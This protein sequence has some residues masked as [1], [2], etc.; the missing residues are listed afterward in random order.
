MDNQLVCIFCKA[1]FH[2]ADDLL[3]HIRI[4]TGDYPEIDLVSNDSEETTSVVSEATVSTVSE[5]TLSNFN[6]EEKEW[7]GSKSGWSKKDEHLGDKT[8]GGQ[9]YVEDEIMKEKS[10]LDYNCNVLSSNVNPESNYIVEN[11]DVNPVENDFQ[12]DPDKTDNVNRGSSQE[13]DEFGSNKDDRCTSGPTQQELDYLYYL[14]S[15]SNQQP[16]TLQRVKRQLLQQ[17]EDVQ[18]PTLGIGIDSA[19]TMPKIVSVQGTYVHSKAE[20]G[21]QSTRPGNV[22]NSNDVPGSK[23]LSPLYTGSGSTHVE[24]HYLSMQP[25]IKINA[26]PDLMN[27]REDEVPL[28]ISSSRYEDKVQLSSPTESCTSILPTCSLPLPS[29]MTQGSAT[30]PSTSGLFTGS[31]V[32]HPVLSQADISCSLPPFIYQDIGTVSPASRAI[33]RSHRINHPIG[34]PPFPPSPTPNFAASLPRTSPSSALSQLPLHM[35]PLYLS[36]SVSTTPWVPFHMQALYPK[37]NTCSTAPSTMHVPAVDQD[38][39]VPDL[40]SVCI[41]TSVTTTLTSMSPS[42]KRVVPV[43]PTPARNSTTTSVTASTSASS[44]SKSVFPMSPCRGGFLIKSPPPKHLMLSP[45]REWSR[46][47]PKSI[48]PSK[49]SSPKTKTKTVSLSV[50][51]HSDILSRIRYEPHLKESFKSQ[52][53]HQAENRTSLPECTEYKKTKLLSKTE[54]KK[55]VTNSETLCSEHAFGIPPCNKDDLPTVLP[56][57][58]SAESTKSTKDVSTTKEYTASGPLCNRNGLP[59]RVLP[60]VPNKSQE[61]T[62]LRKSESVPVLPAASPFSEEESQSTLH[63]RVLPT[64]PQ[65]SP[66]QVKAELSSIAAGL[67]SNNGDGLQPPTRRFHGEHSTFTASSPSSSGV[68]LHKEASPTMHKRVLPTLPSLSNKRSAELAPST[69]PPSTDEGLLDKSSVSMVDVSRSKGIPAAP[70]S[71]EDVSTELCTKPPCKP[72]KVSTDIST[73]TPKIPSGLFTED[74]SVSTGPCTKPPRK[75]GTVSSGMSVARPKRPPTLSIGGS[76]STGLCTKPPCKFGKASTGTSTTR[77]KGPSI[78]P[79]TKPPPCGPGKRLKGLSS[80]KSSP[81]DSLI[82][83]GSSDLL[84][85]TISSTVSAML[86]PTEE[87]T[88]S[89]NV[90]TKDN[91][92][93]SAEGNTSKLG[94]VSGPSSTETDN[95]HTASSSTQ[96]VPSASSPIKS[97]TSG[98]VTRLPLLKSES[99]DSDDVVVIPPS[100]LPWNTIPTSVHQSV[101]SKNKAVGRQTMKGAACNT[102]HEV[103]QRPLKRKKKSKEARFRPYEIRRPEVRIAC[104]ASKDLPSELLNKTKEIGKKVFKK[105]DEDDRDQQNQQL[106]QS[107]KMP[108]SD[109]NISS[110]VAKLIDQLQSRVQSEEFPMAEKNVC[111]KFTIP[112]DQPQP[113]QSKEFPVAEKSSS[114]KLTKPVVNPIRFQCPTCKRGFHRITEQMKHK[115]KGKQ[116]EKSPNL[117]TAY[118]R[119]KMFKCLHCLTEFATLQEKSQHMC[120]GKSNLKKHDDGNSSSDAKEGKMRLKEAKKKPG[121]PKKDLLLDS[122]YY[123]FKCHKCDKGFLKEPWLRA[124]VVFCQ[125]PMEVEDRSENLHTS[126]EAK[127]VILKPDTVIEQPGKSLQKVAPQSEIKSI[128]CKGCDKMF[129]YKWNLKLHL[130]WSNLC[131]EA[132]DA[133][134]FDKMCA[135]LPKK[136]GHSDESSSSDGKEAEVKGVKRKQGQPETGDGLDSALG[137]FKCQRCDRTFLKEPWMKAHAVFCENPTKKRDKSRKHRQRG[138]I[139]KSEHQVSF[140]PEAPENVQCKGC[141]RF[142]KYRFNLKLHLKWKSTCRLKFNERELQKV[143]GRTHWDNASA[144]I[145]SQD[146]NS[147]TSHSAKVSKDMNSNSMNS[148]DM[149]VQINLSKKNREQK[150][151]SRKPT[152]IQ[153]RKEETDMSSMATSEDDTENEH[154]VPHQEGSTCPFCKDSKRTFQ[155]VQFLSMHTMYAHNK[156]VHAKQSRWYFGD[157]KSVDAASPHDVTG[158]SEE[159]EGSS[160]KQIWKCS[161]CPDVNYVFISKESYI[162]HSVAKHGL[163]AV[164]DSLIS[165]KKEEKGTHPGSGV[166]L[167][168]ARKDEIDKVDQSEV[169]TAKKMSEHPNLHK[170]MQGIDVANQKTKATT[171]GMGKSGTDKRSNSDV[172]SGIKASPPAKVGDFIFVKNSSSV[173]HGMKERPMTESSSSENDVKHGTYKCS[174]CDCGFASPSFAAINRHLMV[175]HNIR[176]PKIVATLTCKDPV[177]LGKFISVQKKSRP[178]FCRNTSGFMICSM[179]NKDVAAENT[180]LHAKKHLLHRLC[181]CT[182]CEYTSFNRGKVRKHLKRVHSDVVEEAM[183]SSKPLEVPEVERSCSPK[184]SETIAT[185]SP[186]TC[187]TIDATSSI[188][189]LETLVEATSRP[190]ICEAI[191]ATS[192][193]KSLG[194]PEA[195]KGL[196]AP[197]MSA[198]ARSPKALEKTE[199]KSSTK[200]LEKTKITTNTKYLQKA[201]ATRSA[202]SLEMAE[203]TNSLRSLEKTE[204]RYDLGPY[205]DIKLHESIGECRSGIKE[206]G[207]KQKYRRKLGGKVSNPNLSDRSSLENKNKKTAIA[208]DKDFFKD[209]NDDLKLYHCKQCDFKSDTYNNISIHV[210]VT[211]RSKSDWVKAS[212]VY[213]KEQNL[214]ALKLARRETFDKSSGLYTCSLCQ[215]KVARNS[216]SRHMLQHTGGCPYRCKLCTYQCKQRTSILVHVGSVH[217]EEDYLA[218]VSHQDAQVSKDDVTDKMEETAELHD[219]DS[220]H[221]A[222]IFDDAVQKERD[223]LELNSKQ[224]KIDYDTGELRNSFGQSQ[225]ESAPKKHGHTGSTPGM[226]LNGTLGKTQSGDQKT[227]ASKKLKAA[228]QSASS[229]SSNTKGQLRNSSSDKALEYETK[230]YCNS[231]QQPVLIQVPAESNNPAARPGSDCKIT[232]YNPGDLQKKRKQEHVGTENKQKQRIFPV[233]SEEKHLKQALVEKSEQQ[234]SQRKRKHEHTS[235][236]SKLKK[237]RLLQ[238]NLEERHWKQKLLE[239]SEQEM[240]QLEKGTSVLASEN[241]KSKKHKVSFEVSQSGEEVSG[242][243]KKE[244]LSSSKLQPTNKDVFLGKNQEQKVL[245]EV[246]RKY[247]EVSDDQKKQRLKDDHDTNMNCEEIGTSAS[248][249]V[250]AQARVSEKDE[251]VSSAQEKQRLIS[252]HLQLAK[253]AD[254][255]QRKYSKSSLHTDPPKNL[256]EQQDTN[257]D[258]EKSDTTSDAIS[259]VARARVEIDREKSLYSCMDCAM[260]IESWEEME[261]HCK[262][263]TFYYCFM[264]SFKSTFHTVVLSHEA[265]CHKDLKNSS[266]IHKALAQYDTD[267]SRKVDKT[268]IGTVPASTKI[269][270]CFVTIR[271][272]S[273]NKSFRPLQKITGNFICRFCSFESKCYKDVEEHTKRHME[274]QKAYHCLVCSYKCLQQSQMLEHIP[275]HFKDS[276]DGR[277]VGSC[278][279]KG[280]PDVNHGDCNTKKMNGTGDM[281]DETQRSQEIKQVVCASSKGNM[282]ADTTSSDDLPTGKLS[283]ENV[284]RSCWVEDVTQRNQDIKQVDCNSTNNKTRDAKNNDDIIAEVFVEKLSKEH[285]NEQCCVG[286]ENT[287]KNQAT[288]ANDSANKTNDAENTDGVSVERLFKELSS[289]ICIKDKKVPVVGEVSTSSKSADVVTKNTGDMTEVILNSSVERFSKE[290]TDQTC[291]IEDMAKSSLGKALTTNAKSDDV[292]VVD[293][294]DVNI[295]NPVH[296]EE[297]KDGANV[298]QFE[299]SVWK[300]NWLWLN[301][302]KDEYMKRSA[303]VD[304]LKVSETN[305]VSLSYVDVSDS[306]LS[307]DDGIEVTED[308]DDGVVEKGTSADGC[309]EFSTVSS[310]IK[311]VEASPTHVVQKIEAWDLKANKPLYISA[312]AKEKPL[313]I[314]DGV[315]YQPLDRQ[316]SVCDN[317]E[318]L[319]KGIPESVQVDRFDDKSPTTADGLEGQSLEVEDCSKESKKQSGSLQMNKFDNESSKLVDDLEGEKTPESLDC[320]KLTREQIETMEASPYCAGPDPTDHSTM[321]GGRSMTEIQGDPR[322]DK[323]DSMTPKTVGIGIPGGIQIISNLELDDSRTSVNKTNMAENSLKQFHQQLTISSYKK[324]I[325][326]SKITK[327]ATVSTVVNCHTKSTEQTGGDLNNVLVDASLKLSN[328]GSKPAV[329]CTQHGRNVRITQGSELNEGMQL[330]LLQHPKQEEDYR[331]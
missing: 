222:E 191:E 153:D 281:K 130:K 185:S 44:F 40:S 13:Y 268:E 141:Q 117:N 143:C 39:R 243:Q 257:L 190:M 137:K 296:N 309:E 77:P 220:P 301:K 86:S 135:K 75:L 267:S 289:K 179:C 203:S 193:S 188:K 270:E 183:V 319:C 150:S 163:T 173:L 7:T 282:T 256:E 85:S 74:R 19:M 275:S 178:S 300:C 76:I 34:L 201:E 5:E 232:R 240:L 94:G 288:K 295:I 100:H 64:V 114:P 20:S 95:L 155:S 297:V 48:S 231:K 45:S 17:F 242:A 129:K 234:D 90:F 278:Q 215:L 51:R 93:L 41:S 37:I 102:K 264:C 302:D 8:F 4:H 160:P 206:L 213:D 89:V 253:I 57:P 310:I 327:T 229:M 224:S 261:E 25:C 320:C 88:V 307:S 219:Q 71:T 194:I 27:H 202:K 324:T 50:S 262:M 279:A 123:R 14:Q 81:K 218:H 246:S 171:C 184:C 65:L 280:R 174:H 273:Y 28:T 287:Q 24:R 205:E 329:R 258:L 255:F 91:C 87:E 316:A 122:K 61:S 115:C 132:F 162:C 68:G 315:V 214:E 328:S 239:K 266:Q 10:V 38:I 165:S 156:T 304:N 212:C 192:S 128:Q 286:D 33:A 298:K 79:C 161:L 272:P 104:S 96:A 35:L 284:N 131:K 54:C 53:E 97:V 138:T 46:I 244:M 2:L 42:S 111:S 283:E 237:Q 6:S 254:I 144:K 49:T 55:D 265:L 47:P 170:K 23:L 313:V 146:M 326:P 227:S 210:A 235:T 252:N 99:E 168:G 60:T 107:E 276:Q 134:E 126:V 177:T 169:K 121:R 217:S 299:R 9:D 199:A 236:E 147:H 187:E 216:L 325:I 172:Q 306:Y 21:E 228:Q 157:V 136:R 18:S 208:K 32:N 101:Y 70:S 245:L 11:S 92:T 181:K 195:T 118:E 260:E 125:T 113:V 294:K 82:S 98:S 78:G 151:T 186:R 112:I 175:Q 322:L 58:R 292:V 226:K 197:E 167:D 321:T 308:G 318:A 142:F 241:I 84:L 73:A 110:R 36:K 233:H 66:K 250:L 204:A 62:S 22:A 223:D 274:A 80:G 124:H 43:S 1:T 225:F 109:K 323:D 196:K 56:S 29:F 259:S 106:V 277:A 149:N 154:V 30:A 248:S 271:I 133:G 69:S 139:K 105:I 166:H 238:V 312:E 200:L 290:Q 247:E 152:K 127:P 207:G 314:S 108:M 116:D 331:N 119:L 67:P 182:L 140:A 269:K 198:V 15:E 180:D 12:S 83:T 72:S 230:K 158:V 189:A 176:Q 263:H 305:S 31:H 211:H 291:C 63:R 209:P 285:V 249:N 103:I 52:S 159:G 26:N 311:T 293:C 251:E 303:A 148:K 164:G 16:L 145:V 221:S 317:N 120:E 3:E 330:S 59:K